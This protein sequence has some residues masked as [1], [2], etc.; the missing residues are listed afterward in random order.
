MRPMEIIE[1]IESGLK[2]TGK[3]K[4]GLGLAICNDKTVGT[5][6][7]NGTRQVRVK[8]LPVIAEYIEETSIPIF[9]G[10]SDSCGYGNREIDDPLFVLISSRG[11]TLWREKYPKVK[12]ERVFEIIKEVYD[13][14]SKEPESAQTAGL[15]MLFEKESRT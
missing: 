3:T 14:F 9:D 12:T 6:I 2:R 13:R 11:L 15:D 10:P 1:W 7:L 5:K 8:E 4:T